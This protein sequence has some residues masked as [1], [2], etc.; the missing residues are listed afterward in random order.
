MHG[1]LPRSW[2]ALWAGQPSK[3]T[4]LGE[5]RLKAAGVGEQAGRR[6][7]VWRLPLQ[8]RQHPLPEPIQ[9]LRVR[10]NTALC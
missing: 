8:R 1:T 6:E 3:K 5:G 7:Q 4:R 9:A 2:H 10:S